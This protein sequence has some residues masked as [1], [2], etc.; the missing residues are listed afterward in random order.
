MKK[1]SPIGIELICEFES[2]AAKSYPDVVGVWTIGYGT[3]RVNG[4]PV[5]KGMTCSLEQAQAWMAMELGNVERAINTIDA[6][7]LLIQSQFDACAALAYNIGVSGF[8]GSTI[9]KKIQAG[10][11]ATITE[12]NF[13]AWNKVRENGVLVESRGLTRRR[14]SEFHLFRTGEL[15]TT[16]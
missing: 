16:F 8:S 5:T 9:A 2:F 6:K 1:T 15:K 7:G 3:T 12:S 10:S 13:V 4:Q 14:R 11:I